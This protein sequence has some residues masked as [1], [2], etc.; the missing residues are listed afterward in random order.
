[1][2]ITEELQYPVVS[3]ITPVVIYLSPRSMVDAPANFIGP[4]QQFTQ[5]GFRVNILH[6]ANVL[7]MTT[8]EKQIY[9]LFCEWC[10]L[11]FDQIVLETLGDSI[12]VQQ[13]TTERQSE[14]VSEV[15]SLHRRV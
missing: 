12:L 6:S 4:S 5:F 15:K 9:R 11:T 1:M 13:L 14:I 8:S 3:D 2:F 7:L 10:G